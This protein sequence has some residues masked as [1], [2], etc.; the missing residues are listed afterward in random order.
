MLVERLDEVPVETTFFCGW[1]C[2]DDALLTSKV[3]VVSGGV[4][5][6][7]ATCALGLSR[8]ERCRKDLPGW[9]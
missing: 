7:L 3:G 6:G 4:A 9:T 1:F 8:S 5:G 2:I